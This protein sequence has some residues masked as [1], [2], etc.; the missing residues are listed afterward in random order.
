M[1]APS[2]AA[3]SRT[4]RATAGR[5]PARAR[6]GYVTPRPTAG[7]IYE[8]RQVGTPSSLGLKSG[9][10]D[11]PSGV[12]HRDRDLIRHPGC[13]DHES[14][15]AT[16]DVRLPMPP[17]PRRVAT[18]H[19]DAHHD[20]PCRV[21]GGRSRDPRC[22]ST[23]M[24]AGWTSRFQFQHQLSQL[25]GGQP[26]RVATARLAGLSD[27]HSRPTAGYLDPTTVRVFAALDLLGVALHGEPFA[28]N[29]WPT[30]YPE[31]EPAAQRGWVYFALSLL[32]HDR[33]VGK[34]DARVDR[35]AGTLTVSA[36][37]E[38]VRFTKPVRRAVDREIADL[39]AWLGLTV[40]SRRRDG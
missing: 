5:G 11:G 29:S 25:A 1:S 8:T 31:T 15:I 20:D 32:H 40:R 24:Q 34:L 16:A 13:P 7:T 33:R 22:I 17:P 23:G 12:R 36:I 6:C 18:L 30:V 35:K 4:S 14:L 39:A 19:S 9:S 37:H 26:Q 2:L 21:S 10:P 27:C 28:R 38:D 3:P